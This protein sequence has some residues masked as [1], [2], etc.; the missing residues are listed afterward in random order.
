MPLNKAPLHC[1][2]ALQNGT[3][4]PPIHHTS[5]SLID[6][7]TTYTPSPWPT[8]MHLYPLRL[9]VHLLPLP[10]PPSR[11]DLGQQLEAKRDLGSSVPSS[12]STN[13][14]AKRYAIDTINRR[15]KNSTD[16]SPFKQPTPCRPSNSNKAMINGGAAVCTLSFYG[17]HRPVTIYVSGF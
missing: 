8:T 3:Q 5:T 12:L 10:A 7:F 13:P 15:Y 17:A 2:F 4:S 11:P 14:Y 9:L 1:I 6:R 16:H